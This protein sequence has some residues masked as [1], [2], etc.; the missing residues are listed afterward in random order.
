MWIRSEATARGKTRALV[1]LVRAQEVSEDLP[2]G[3]VISGR[4]EIS[5][6]GHKVL[7]DAQG[8]SSE[9]GI[10]AVRCTPQ[11]LEFTPCLGHRLGGGLLSSALNS[12]LSLLNHQISPNIAQTGWGNQPAMTAEARARLRATAIADGTYYAA[13]TCPSEA[14]LSGSIVYIENANCSY[15]SNTQFNSPE[16]PGMVVLANGSLSLSGTTKFYGIVYHANEANSTGEAV[17]VHGNG[18]VFGGVLVDG[19]ATTVAGSSK[20]NIQLDP[21]AFTAVRSYGSAGIV[22]NTWREITPAG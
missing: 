18:R 15:T 20:L 7:I 16:E 4:L 11:L 19:N 22:Q 3:A 13:G 21:N 5:N 14:G 8:G 12:L 1:A 9:S 17:R 10:V 6:N 2:R